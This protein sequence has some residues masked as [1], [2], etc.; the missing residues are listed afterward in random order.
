[1]TV[2]VAIFSMGWSHEIG[3]TDSP[4][5]V[6]EAI[7]ARATAASFNCILAVGGLLISLEKD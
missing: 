1:M 4:A 7:A 6:T 2:L 3:S 5:D